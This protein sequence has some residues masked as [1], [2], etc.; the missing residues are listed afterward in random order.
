MNTYQNLEDRLVDFAS[1]IISLSAKLKANYAQIHLGK[2]IIRS[3]TS[4]CLNYG[5]AQCAESTKDFI[6]KLKVSLKELKETSLALKILLKCNFESTDQMKDLLNENMQ[7]IA[8]FL[9]SIQTA[10]NNQLKKTS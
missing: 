3:S 5:E 7:L 2:Q 8:I 9:K 1:Q 4:A 6:H 10:R